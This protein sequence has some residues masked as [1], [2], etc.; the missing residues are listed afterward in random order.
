MHVDYGLTAYDID[1]LH[2]LM[3][4]SKRERLRQLQVA[5]AAFDIEKTMAGKG[6]HTIRRISPQKQKTRKRHRIMK[7]IS[8]RTRVPNKQQQKNNTSRMGFRQELSLMTKGDDALGIWGTRRSRGFIAIFE[9]FMLHS[10]AF[11]STRH[12]MCITKFYQ[13]LAHSGVPGVQS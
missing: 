5:K 9:S 12:V 11:G 10:A 2:T 13:T 7:H 4:E 6:Q 3:L 1:A 8:I